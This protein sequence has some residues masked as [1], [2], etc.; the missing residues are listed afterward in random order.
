MPAAE[1]T[2]INL[3][4]HAMGNAGLAQTSLSQA[5]VAA[6]TANLQSME[7]DS[8]M[9]TAQQQAEATVIGNLFTVFRA[10]NTIAAQH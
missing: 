1:S 10:I 5:N 7:M 6:T 8:A 9:T 3:L 2:G 4:T